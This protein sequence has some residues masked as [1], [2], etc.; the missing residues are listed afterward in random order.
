MSHSSKVEPLLPL[1]RNRVLDSQPWQPTHCHLK[2]NRYYRVI[3]D[4][5]RESDLAHWVVYDNIQGDVFM[6]P[7][8]EFRDGRFKA[9]AYEPKVRK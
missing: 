5:R 2:T 7:V 9:L 6:R 4:G 1:Y 8:E 3:C